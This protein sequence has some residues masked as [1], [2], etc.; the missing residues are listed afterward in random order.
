MKDLRELTDFDDTLE[1]EPPRRSPLRV[2]PHV[3]V[4]GYLTHKKTNPSRTLPWAYA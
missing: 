4:Q 2:N 1:T 3:E